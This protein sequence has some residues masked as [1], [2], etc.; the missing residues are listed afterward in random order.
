[1]WVLFAGLAALGVLYAARSASG[2]PRESRGVVRVAGMS[3]VRLDAVCVTKGSMHNGIVDI[4]TFRAVALGT[5]GEAASIDFIYQGHSTTSRALASGQVRRQ[6]GLKLRAANGCNL[7]YVMWRLDPRP[8]IEASVKI[9]PGSRT[10][11]E[12]G[13]QGYTKLGHAAAPMMIEGKRHT[14]QAEIS[15]D[16]LLAWI[17]GQ[18]VWRG[19][20]PDEARSISGPSGFRS[21]NV[22]YTIVAISAP[23]GQTGAAVP[24]C[25]SDGED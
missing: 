3:P 7:V 22:S 16:E 11:A 4:P 1:M 25:V 8:Q 13:A 17:D 14:L 6:I 10:H 21:D 19:Q 15:N 24:R 18:L 9:N 23:V 5:S 2:S 20:L 12:C